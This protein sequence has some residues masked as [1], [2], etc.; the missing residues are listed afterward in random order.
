VRGAGPSV[1][2]RP[3]GFLSRRSRAVGVLLATVAMVATVPL[4]SASAANEP[5]I[6]VSEDAFTN[7]TSQ[8]RTEVE[9]DTFAFGSTWVSAFQ[10]G[11]FVS[12]GA[13]GIGFATSS[14]QGQSFVQ[15]FLPEVTTFSDPP[16][17]YDRATDPSVA[18]DARH[19]VWLISYIAIHAGG[20]RDVLVS[21]S[22]DG[23][24]WDPPVAVARLNAVLDKDWMVCDNSPDSRFAGNCYAEFDVLPSRAEQ[25]TTST[26]GG[27][28]W[29]AP[30]TAAFGTGGQPLVQPNG[31]V[32]VPFRGLCAGAVQM[33]AYSSDDGG[34]TWKAPVVISTAPFHPTVPV[35][36]SPPLPSGAVDGAGR[37]YVVWK[38][39]RFEAGCAANDIVLS[40][41]DDGTSWRP[42]GRIPLDPA[43]ANVDHFIP[44]IGVD[45]G[46][47]NGQARLALTFYFC[48]LTACE[49]DVGF[50]SSTDGGQT[51]SR[52]EL[53]AGP[54]PLSWL[55]Q[56]DQGAMVGD[57]VSTSVLT[58]LVE[59]GGG[60][61]LPLAVPAFAAATPPANGTLREAIFAARQEIRGGQLPIENMPGLAE[62]ARRSGA[63]R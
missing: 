18:F 43:G 21:R 3:R 62:P 12:E 47:A 36:R 16:G 49:L 7:A 2:S 41:S 37:I 45:P 23:V 31:R 51:W 1:Q 42:V 11:R 33:C 38:D 26:D 57:Y 29:G 25:V 54:M 8:H 55:A 63:I 28:T 17:P 22:G 34:G 15:G 39:C 60:R 20:S 48:P 27:L 40:T 19:Q 35:L 32:V 24:Q 14:D 61:E 58:G 56:T 44:G 59:P 5:V 30:L 13:S 50:V 52:P 6:Q 4:V 53:L 10:A 46:S 9:P